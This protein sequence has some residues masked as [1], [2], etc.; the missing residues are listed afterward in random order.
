MESRSKV[1]STGK[2]VEIFGFTLTG[3]IG[4]VLNVII[5]LAVLN[6]KRPY[7]CTK[8]SLHLG[9]SNAIGSVLVII[10]QGFG[11][12]W[13]IE[14]SVCH[15]F[16]VFKSFWCISAMLLTCFLVY[17]SFFKTK[18][19]LKSLQKGEDVEKAEENCLNVRFTI[20]LVWVS[21]CTVA[22]ITFLLLT[23]S[24]NST[25]CIS[26]QHTRQDL[27]RFYYGF[28]V[29]LPLSTIAIL[30]ILFKRLSINQKKSVGIYNQ[31]PGKRIIQRHLHYTKSCFRLGQVLQ[32]MWLPHTVYIFCLINWFV[33]NISFH[34]M[35]YH[36]LKLL[37][38][39]CYLSSICQ[40]IALIY[41]NYQIKLVVLAK[42]KA[43]WYSSCC[44]SKHTAP[45]DHN[46]GSQLS[47]DGIENNESST[48]CKAKPAEE[49]SNATTNSERNIQNETIMH[50][51]L[52]QNRETVTVHNEP[53]M[54]ITTSQS[55]SRN[56]NISSSDSEYG[57][58]ASPDTDQD[59]DMRSEWVLSDND[60]LN[61][62]T[63]QDAY[64]EKEN[65][66]NDDDAEEKNMTV[67]NAENMNQVLDKEVITNKNENGHIRNLNISQPNKSAKSYQN[68]STVEIKEEIAPNENVS[69][70][71]PERNIDKM[72]SMELAD[73]DSQYNS[74]VSV[75][76][77]QC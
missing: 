57:Y 36:M 18:S 11:D 41:T 63:Q 47:S 73:D 4:F 45:E 77:S 32:M 66:V 48:N 23:D 75:Q 64:I 42:T 72:F 67:Q 46:Q 68:E 69:P 17:E 8:I 49:I 56:T 15:L 33:D 70:F 24:L 59:E 53:A 19:R 74:S 62:I 65:N 1:S 30:N 51:S 60:N 37:Q 27:A 50:S 14:H 6:I 76:T 39:F 52:S 43:F 9:I 38:W 10:I 28:I 21:S 12:T 20:I 61:Q 44:N 22:F 31:R 25:L 40:P 26:Y 5:V 34:E 16:L 71:R 58:P 55:F 29:I 3:T 54:K 7:I 35:A 13:L 2:A